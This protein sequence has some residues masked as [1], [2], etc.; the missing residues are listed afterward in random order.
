MKIKR[1]DKT[2]VD[3]KITVLREIEAYDIPSEDDPGC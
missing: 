2:S 3:K 1:L